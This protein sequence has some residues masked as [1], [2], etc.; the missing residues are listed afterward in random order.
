M[1]LTI[2]PEEIKVNKTS[3]K[4]HNSGF[5]LIEIIIVLSL[6][7]FV[8][9]IAMPAIFGPSANEIAG[10]LGRLTADIRAAYDEAVLKRKYFRL[11]FNL[12]SGDYWL[13]MTESTNVKFGDDRFEVD[14]TEDQ[15][16][17]VKAEFESQFL[18]YE[19]LAGETIHD[20]DSD[21]QIKPESP[22]LNAK[23]SLAPPVWD[24]VSS[25]EW[26]RRSLGDALIIRDMQAEHHKRKVSIEEDGEKA[27]AFIYFF[28]NG[29]VENAYI[30]VYYRKGD[31]GFDEEKEPYTIKTLP[32]EG[33]ATIVD[34]LVE[35]DLTKEDEDEN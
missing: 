28:P 13:E 6:M 14:P 23:D 17:E 10:K 8:F 1:K 31:I 26:K 22:V 12:A 25:L 24:V 4:S 33:V 7:G 20:P 16:K 30:H 27:R 19:D 18:E 3:K 11:V 15:E 2:V 21:K 35:I 29:Y 5:T 9:T 34:G 32:W